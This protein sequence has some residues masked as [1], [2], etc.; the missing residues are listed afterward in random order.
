MHDDHRPRSEPNA[1]GCYREPI[2]TI[3]TFANFLTK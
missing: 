3:P 1:A 2:V